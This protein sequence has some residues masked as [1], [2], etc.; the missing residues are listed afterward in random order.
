MIGFVSVTKEE[1]KKMIDEA[2][3]EMVTII[4]W[5]RATLIHQPT[6]RKHKTVGKKLV[7]LANEVSFADDDIFQTLCLNG[8]VREPDLLRNILLPKFKPKLE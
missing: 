1:A 2:P 6:E 5:N 4:T 3:G 8:E 7:D